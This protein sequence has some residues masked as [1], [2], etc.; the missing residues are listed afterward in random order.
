M[1]ARAREG[2]GRPVCEC[3]WGVRLSIR[4]YVFK[5]GAEVLLLVEIGQA[6][7]QELIYMIASKKTTHATLFR[8]VCCRTT[9]HNHSDH[10]QYIP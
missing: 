3:E 1:R 7:R 9:E 10:Y 5:L 4:A 8:A 2:E 6:L